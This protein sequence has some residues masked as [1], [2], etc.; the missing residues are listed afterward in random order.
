[1]LV[2]IKIDNLSFKIK[3]EKV[4]ATV[5][6]VSDSKLVSFFVLLDDLTFDVVALDAELVFDLVSVDIINNDFELL[7]RGPEHCNQMS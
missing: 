2:H 3:Y 6:K 7:V 4:E 1:M 5:I